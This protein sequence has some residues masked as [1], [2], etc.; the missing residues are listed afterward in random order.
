MRRLDYNKI[1]LVISLVFITMFCVLSVKEYINYDNFNNSAPF[2][3]A[4]LMYSLELL[5]P[6]WLLLY[7]YN[8]NTNLKQTNYLVKSK[9][10]P[11]SFNE[12]KIAHISDFHNTNSKRIKSTIIETLKKNAP[13]VIVITGDLIDSRRTNITSAIDFL[14]SIINIAPVY[15]VLGNHESRL[16]DTKELIEHAENIGVNVLRNISVQI[17]RQGHTIDI[18]GLDDPGFYITLENANEILEKTDRSLNKVVKLNDKFSILLTH[19]PELIKLYS[20]YNFD[21]IF[22][23]HAHG[24]Q[25]RIPGIGGIIAPGQGLFPKYTRG[26]YSEHNTKMVLS[27]GIGNS[28]FPFRINNRPEIVFV[29]LQK[30]E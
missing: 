29:T 12:F 14:K 22:T 23:G 17:T 24:G 6:G 20:K 15:F 5:L 8:A 19:R 7:L 30:D 4:I 9:K 1:M 25:I 3:V 28:R 27:C 16:R 18:T 13:D 26:I 11:E 2:Y 10:L 21:L